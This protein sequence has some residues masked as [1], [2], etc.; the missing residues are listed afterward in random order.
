M[1]GDRGPGIRGQ[2]DDRPGQDG[3]Q[4]PGAQG[5][6]PEVAQC[7]PRLPDLRR[8]LH[9]GHDL[10]HAG[11]ERQGTCEHVLPCARPVDGEPGHVYKCF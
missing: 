8:A 3:P 5:G 9:G 7:L 4:L 2:A 10:L 11:D 1:R 6:D